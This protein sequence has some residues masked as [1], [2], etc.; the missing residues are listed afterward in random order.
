MKTYLHYGVNDEGRHLWVLESDVRVPRRNIDN[1]GVLEIAASSFALVPHAGAPGKLRHGTK[2]LA[3]RY[4]Q[5][6]RWVEYSA[7]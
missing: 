2:E 7:G 6:K 4:N 3:F 5:Y 1:A